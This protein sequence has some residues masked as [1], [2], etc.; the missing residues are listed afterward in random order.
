MRPL[1]RNCVEHR[2]A[3]AHRDK[4]SIRRENDG[5]CSVMAVGR[6]QFVGSD[7]HGLRGLMRPLS[8]GLIGLAIAVAIW[9]FAYKLSLYQPHP[10]HSAKASVA[11]LWLGP[12][13]NSLTA[14]SPKAHLQPRGNLDVA[15]VP[16]PSIPLYSRNG[17]WTASKAAVAVKTF[18]TDCPPRSPPTED[19]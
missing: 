6:E 5:L 4:S 19:I 12:E 10:S 1:P 11:K 17:T 18:F 8:L 14:K 15:F 3:R 2:A 16:Q 7:L 9:G 13:G